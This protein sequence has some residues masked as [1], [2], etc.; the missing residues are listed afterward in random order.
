M[1]SPRLER[2]A[3]KKA[4]LYNFRCP[5]C[6]DSKKQKSKCRGYV[7]RKKNDYFFVC[8]NCGA[9]HTFYNFLNVIDPT[10][11]RAYS[12]ERYSDGETTHH[13]YPKPD[14]EE[15]KTVAPIFKEKLD[16]PTIADLEDNHYAKQY[17]IKRMIPIKFH[18]QLYFTEDFKTFV[19]SF[20]VEKKGLIENEHR[21]VIPFY[22]GKKNL[23]N[24][25][26][27]ALRETKAKYIT[28]SFD[29][30]GHK[31]YGLD[32]VN[33]DEKVYVLEGPFDSMFL[34][35][36]I[37]TAD[38]NLKKA[39]E[40]GYKDMVIIYDNEPRNKEIVKFMKAAIVTGLYI[41]IFPESIQE[42]DI[43]DIILSGKTQEQV[44]FL[45]DENTYCG[46]RAQLEFTK[47]KKV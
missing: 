34:P 28:I 32:K 43:N 2:F 31:M 11:V 1:I 10:L 38:S 33:P 45:I 42:K 13:N 29:E 39:K 27:R 40:L 6:G 37:A 46:L 12:M 8:H 14:Y 24:V 19:E 5:I 21:I 22:D 47:W 25:Q 9:G 18:S 41:C 16:L 35:N 4:D 26:G 20:E 23:V 30:N 44:K 36:A 3:Q 15:M 7:Y 17:I